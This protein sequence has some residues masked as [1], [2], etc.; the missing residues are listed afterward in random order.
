M[1]F[2]ISELEISINI[3]SNFSLILEIQIIEFSSK[4]NIKIIMM[5]INIALIIIKNID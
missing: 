3:N 1:S 4:N 5:I 2:K